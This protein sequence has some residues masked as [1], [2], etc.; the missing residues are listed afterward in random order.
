MTLAIGHITIF[1][2][3]FGGCLTTFCHKKTADIPQKGMSAVDEERDYNLP[4]C[5]SARQSAQPRSMAK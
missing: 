2:N 4:D 1:R 5:T 3:V